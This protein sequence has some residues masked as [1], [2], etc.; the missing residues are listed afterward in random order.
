MHSFPFVADD[1]PIATR[2]TQLITLM[3]K[4]NNKNNKLMIMQLKPEAG[5]SAGPHNLIHHAE[6][7]R[8]PAFETCV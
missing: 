1:D 2:R 6:E 8:A 7:L 3:H 4:I 5:K